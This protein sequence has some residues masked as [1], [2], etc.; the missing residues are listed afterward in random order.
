MVVSWGRR[1]LGGDG[2]L[3]GDGG[4]FVAVE[5]ALKNSGQR[6]KPLW[7]PRNN[8]P[9]LRKRVRHG[10][11]LRP[12]PSSAPSLRCHL[13]S[14]SLTSGT[15]K[16]EVVVALVGV[17]PVAKRRARVR[18]PLNQDPPRMTREPEA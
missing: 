1:E 16:T 10:R 12:P 11:R 9:P 4:A 18:A 17:V 14:R 6:G 2:F 7:N 3:G 15:A 13:S 5:G 8:P